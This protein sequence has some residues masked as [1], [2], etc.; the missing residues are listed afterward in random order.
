MNFA[1]KECHSNS[2][3]IE[4]SPNRIRI[5]DVTATAVVRSVGLPSV[6]PSQAAW[7]GSC[8]W[9]CCR[10]VIVVGMFLI[11]ACAFCTGAASDICI[12]VNQTLSAAKLS[13]QCAVVFA[14]LANHLL[15]LHGDLFQGL[16]AMLTK[17]QLR[18]W[19]FA[20]V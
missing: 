9:F 20:I 10:C 12:H 3:K 6:A 7:V 18:L 19:V 2:E 17:K 11:T 1:K 16:Y 8:C 4:I 14:G 13:E 5:S 15:L